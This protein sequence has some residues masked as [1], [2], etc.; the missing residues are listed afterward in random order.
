MK[1]IGLHLNYHI[2]SQHDQI[3]FCL[4]SETSLNN[5]YY[6]SEAFIF[7][8]ADVSYRSRPP[9]ARSLSSSTRIGRCHLF[10]FLFLLT[11]LFYVQNGEQNGVQ[12]VDT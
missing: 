2:L 7:I 4:V 10:A 11:L 6:Y 3:F 9:R 5:Y 12:C 8:I 1:S